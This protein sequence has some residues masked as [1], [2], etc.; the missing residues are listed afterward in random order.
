MKRNLIKVGLVLG[1]VGFLASS[2]QAVDNALSRRLA[3][4]RLHG[5]HK[6]KL[7]TKKSTT[8]ISAEDVKGLTFTDPTKPGHKIVI[9]K[10]GSWTAESSKLKREFTVEKLSGKSIVVTQQN[11]QT[12]LGLEE[13]GP[14]EGLFAEDIPPLG[15]FLQAIP[16]DMMEQMVKELGAEAKEYRFMYMLV[17]GSMADGCF[18]P[19]IG[20]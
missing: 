12:L 14:I 1:L 15:G 8:A 3:F 19:L 17:Y 5:E 7:H 4:Q 20:K 16:E 18:L 6:E 13:F 9:N 10:D 2:A 11:G